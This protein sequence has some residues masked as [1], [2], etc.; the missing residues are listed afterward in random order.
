MKFFSFELFRPS[1]ETVAMASTLHEEWRK[2]RLREDG[3]YEPRVKKTN[4]GAWSR[5]H[6]NKTEVDIANT[7]FKDLPRDRQAENLAA[8]ASAL[9]AVDKHTGKR[10]ITFLQQAQLVELVAGEIH[11]DWVSRD[12]DPERPESDRQPRLHVP[13]GSLPDNEKEKDRVI[14][15]IAIKQ[16]GIVFSFEDRKK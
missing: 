5:K 12:K 15:R 8:A 13:Y 6:G 10:K 2:T 14:A 9:R 7:P 11:A 1:Q 16:R 4:D 3:T